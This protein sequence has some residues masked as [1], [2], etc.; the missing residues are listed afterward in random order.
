MRSVSMGA[1]DDT[2]VWN[3]GDDNDIVEGQTG[4]D[5]LLF[6]GANIAEQIDIAANGSRVLFNRDIAAATM[7]MSE[8]A[9][10]T[11]ARIGDFAASQ[12]QPTLQ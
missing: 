7:D 10:E 1:G 11:G 2:F 12:V 4:F 5:T 6:N 3:P 9:L 8:R